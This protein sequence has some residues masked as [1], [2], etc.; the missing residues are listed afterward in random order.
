MP[1][2]PPAPDRLAVL[3]GTLDQ[4][5]RLNAQAARVAETAMTDALTLAYVPLLAARG[6]DDPDALATA[7]RA[8]HDVAK[9]AAPI[10]T[11]AADAYESVADLIR[12]LA[13][14]IPAAR[15]ALHLLGHDVCPVCERYTYVG[16]A[17]MCAACS[18]AEEA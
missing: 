16:A 14:E 7:I 4:A 13:P 17:I 6:A 5:A 10:A 1:T 2:A 15:P 11:A 9:T 3:I 12:G 18:T 8:A